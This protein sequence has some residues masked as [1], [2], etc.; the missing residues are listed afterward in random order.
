MKVLPK[1]NKDLLLI[2]I[3]EIHIRVYMDEFIFNDTSGTYL[4]SLQ[5]KVVLER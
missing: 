2:K 1:F 5:F 3:F 4:S